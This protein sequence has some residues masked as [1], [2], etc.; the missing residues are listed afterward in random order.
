[1]PALS[2]GWRRTPL[3]VQRSA[4]PSTS[5]RRR[6]PRRADAPSRTPHVSWSPAATGISTTSRGTSTSTRGVACDAELRLEDSG[7]HRCDHRPVGE[8]PEA[9][10]KKNLG[11]AFGGGPEPP[12]DVLRRPTVARRH[13]SGRLHRTAARAVAR[14]L[15]RVL[16]GGRVRAEHP[17]VVGPVQLALGQYAD[18]MDKVDSPR[19]SRCGSRS[20]NAP[21]L[22]HFTPEQLWQALKRRRDGDQTRRSSI[23]GS[24]SGRRFQAEPGKIDPKAEFKSRAGATFRRDSSRCVDRVV[25]ARA[26]TGGA[27]A[28]RLHPDRRDPRHRRPRRRRGAP[29]AADG[30]IFADEA[31]P[32]IPGSTSAARG[33]SSSSTRP[34]VRPWEARR[35]PC[36]TGRPGTTALNVVGTRAAAS[37]SRSSAAARF[38]LLHTPLAPA[39]P[40]AR[41]RLWLLIDLAPRAHLQLVRPGDAEWRAS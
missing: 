33:S 40:T 31:R 3:P 20:P 2:A 16:P 14:R 23:C 28:A 5:A 6:L 27:G 38:M 18:Q 35:G 24:R 8:V 9:R 12:A 17:S 19:S 37:T 15:Q 32:G 4:A 1:M 10:Q 34:R 13:R 22:E 36:R 39:D 30:P 21:E 7:Q 11:Q 41:A 25:S 29:R 26:P